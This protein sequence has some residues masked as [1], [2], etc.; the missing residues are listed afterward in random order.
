[1]S[2]AWRP[3]DC[4]RR[5]RRR[6]LVHLRLIV[7]QR[8]NWCFDSV[9]TL[10]AA[11]P[12]GRRQTPPATANAVDDFVARRRPSLSFFFFCAHALARTRSTLLL[13]SSHHRLPQNFRSDRY[14]RHHLHI[15]IISQQ[16]GLF[17]LPII[18]IIA[19]FITAAI[20]TV[21]GAGR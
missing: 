20:I 17:P 2:V 7:R 12:N 9:Q 18:A 11:P 19:L 6:P 8:N 21:I 4:M 14:P 15:T 13:S 5:P 10:G 3:V 1:M 16:L